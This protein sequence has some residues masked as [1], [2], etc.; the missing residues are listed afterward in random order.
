MPQNQNGELLILS[1]RQ[2]G[3]MES[4]SG[5]QMNAPKIFGR[6]ESEGCDTKTAFVVIHPTSNFMA[7][8]LF[9]P[10]K[11]RGRALLGLNTRYMANDSMLLM[12]RAIQDLGAGIKHLRER[13]YE[14]IVLLGNSG[15]GA[16]AAMYQEQAE[17]LTLTTTPDGRDIDLTPE[18]LPPVDGIALL[19]AHPGR[20]HTLTDWIDPAVTDEHD[21]LSVDPELDMYN[22][23]N[24]PPY[25]AAWLKK[26]RAA[27][28]ARNE[29]LT[30]WVLARLEEV[31]GTAA[32]DQAFIVHRTMADPRFLDLTLDPNDRDTGT[33]WGEPKPINYA[34]NNIG[35]FTTLR[36]FLSQWSMRLSRA[37]GP[38]CLANTTVP[39]LNV[40]YTA[41]K[42]VFPSQLKMWSEAAA[43]RCTD[44]ALEKV[45]H[46]P[47][48]TPE[49]IEEVCD[50]LVDWADNL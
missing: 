32:S 44:Y 13:G 45:G 28:L 34:A 46:Y 47:H 12:E 49:K 19:C 4:Q 43:G 15:G 3:M 21:M 7:H 39:V 1:V 2:G 23:D 17:N 26:Y 11:R 38:N 37:D 10:L 14:K 9:D 30:D 25:E 33:I 50:L 20:A 8:Y 18:D 24:G 48:E 35:R 42:C 40:D 29:C 16:L 31:D 36:S 5:I 27:Q 22:P 41:D 6:L